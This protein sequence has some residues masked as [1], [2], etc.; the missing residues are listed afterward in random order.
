MFL[1][2]LFIGLLALAVSIW[3]ILYIL[4]RNA[5]N[6]FLERPLTFFDPDYDMLNNSRGALR[7]FPRASSNSDHV[8]D[9][10]DGDTVDLTVLVP[11][12]FETLPNELSNHLEE[13]TTYLENRQERY[14]GFTYECIIID[15]AT[16]TSQ[17]SEALKRT[18]SLGSSKYRVLRLPERNGTGSS[19]IAGVSCSRGRFILTCPIGSGIP[20][21][22]LKTLEACMSKNRVGVVVASRVGFVLPMAVSL[23]MPLLGLPS[24]DIDCE[25]MFRLMDRAVALHLCENMKSLGDSAALE[26]VALAR[27]HGIPVHWVKTGIQFNPAIDRRMSVVVYLEAILVH[28]GKYFNIL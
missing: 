13:I 23:V 26:M 19:F 7:P 3:Y 6:A 28:F 9:N 12:P 27:Y 10:P 4:H 21:H 22:Q 1:F 11:M 20:F 25:V 24:A 16:N 15:Q 5:W 14:I 8:R 18:Y 2:F 17:Y